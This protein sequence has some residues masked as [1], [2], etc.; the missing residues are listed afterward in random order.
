MSSTTEAAGKADFSAL[1][2]A[3]CWEDADVLLEGLAIQPGDV[4]LSI[5]SAGD[6]ALAM[7][8]CSPARVIAVDLSFAQIAATHLRVAAY[9]E[10][11]HRELV[12]FLGY[13]PCADRTGLYRRLSGRL[14]PG[15][16]AYWDAHPTALAA[17]AANCGKFENYF[18]IF[19]TRVLPFVHAERNV[20]ALLAP[21]SRAERGV[22][23][24]DRWN[25]WRWRTVFRLFFSRFVMGRLGR[26]PAFF[27]YVEG[28]VADRVLRRAEHALVELDPAE[29]SYLQRILRGEH[30]RELPFALR[31]ENF[32]AI[33]RNIA[34]LET[35]HGSI[36]A[37]LDAHPTLRFD[38]Y[39]LSDIFEYM[40]ED[41]FAA[42]LRRLVD[43][44]RPGA[45]LLYWN[46][47]APRS[48]PPSMAAQ[49]VP[50]EELAQRLHAKDK[51]FFYSRLVIEQV[52]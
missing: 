9:Q 24:R 51:A 37:Y 49:L 41:N 36:E 19:R 11:E 33:R 34:R 32:D 30:A 6:N 31:A 21:R 42:L 29:N 14:E 4:C 16:R 52:A 2:Y 25:S 35:F 3:Q 5:A 8:A 22:F 50:L 13:R 15:V 40:S 20:L 18:R 10:L 28:S 45:R 43:A 26:D 38:R 46:M 17:G 44:G 1:R 27:D 39:N 7:L 47:L 23:Y 12:E 48:R